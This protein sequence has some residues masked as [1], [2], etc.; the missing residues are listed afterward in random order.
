MTSY[1]CPQCL[2]VGPEEMMEVWSG[3]HVCPNCYV[4]L[5]NTWKEV[6]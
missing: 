3:D 2:W 5:D 6:E 4:T 1:Q